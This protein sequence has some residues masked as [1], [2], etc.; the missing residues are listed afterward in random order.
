M[1]SRD[2]VSLLDLLILLILIDP[3]PS[4]TFKQLSILSKEMPISL[5]EPDGTYFLRIG[6]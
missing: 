4:V 6:V 3:N 1:T 2:S 5:R